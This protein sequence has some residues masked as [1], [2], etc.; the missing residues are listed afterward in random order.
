MDCLKASKI[1]S[2][3]VGC[4]ACY[5]CPSHQN[6][7]LRLAEQISTVG[8][9][10]LSAYINFSL[11]ASFLLLGTGIGIY[12]HQ[13]EAIETPNN[14]NGVSCSQGFLEQLTQIKLP[15]FVSLGVNLAI[16]WCHLEHH[17]KIFVPIIALSIGAQI[18]QR[19]L[20]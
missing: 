13:Y 20:I 7:Y 15:S 17:A 14:R 3:K 18:G 2:H 4:I 10:A 6:T 12:Q 5:R 9:A 11:F 16:T 8:L 19:L 1:E